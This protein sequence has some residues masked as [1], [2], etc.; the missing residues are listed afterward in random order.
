MWKFGWNKKFVLSLAGRREKKKKKFHR[1]S[2]MNINCTNN[3]LHRWGRGR[4]RDSDIVAAI[5]FPLSPH[6]VFMLLSRHRF[7]PISNVNEQHISAVMP[8]K[9]RSRNKVAT[10]YMKI[11]I[12]IEVTRIVKD[13]FLNVYSTTTFSFNPS[14]PSADFISSFSGVLSQ[15]SNVNL[16]ITLKSKSFTSI[17]ANLI[18]IR[19]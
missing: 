19:N 2:C 6:F 9:K 18:K 7:R 16:L 5:A 13:H 4:K 10:V 17:N 8:G 15:T 11:D 14:W 12:F 3:F 1:G